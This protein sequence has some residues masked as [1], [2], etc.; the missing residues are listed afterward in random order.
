MRNLFRPLF[1]CCFLYF[2]LS[3]LWVCSC[4]GGKVVAFKLFLCSCL[5]A[6]SGKRL[7]CQLHHFIGNEDVFLVCFVCWVFLNYYYLGFFLFFFLFFW[8][9]ELTET[10]NSLV[11]LK[12]QLCF[13]LDVFLG[14]GG[15]PCQPLSS[16]KYHYP[17]GFLKCLV[18]WSIQICLRFFTLWCLR[19]IN[20]DVIKVESLK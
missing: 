17:L 13:H 7:C 10:A 5:V 2:L 12:V 11:C 4:W 1:L 14:S 19:S 8:G 3:G 6:A 15:L 20:L 18:P 16:S 9:K